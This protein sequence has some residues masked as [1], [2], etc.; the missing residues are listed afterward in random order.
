MWS[1]G[2][3]PTTLAVE[4]I[5]APMTLPILEHGRSNRIRSPVSRPMIT[6]KQ[7]GRHH[8]ENGWDASQAFADDVYSSGGNKKRNVG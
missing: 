8:D 2:E 3:P 5:I 7:E 4:Q 6:R 1:K